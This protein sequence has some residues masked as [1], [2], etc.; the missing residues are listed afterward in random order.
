MPSSALCVGRKS[1]GV[2]ARVASVSG[3]RSTSIKNSYSVRPSVAR[4]RKSKTSEAANQT[5][6]TWRTGSMSASSVPVSTSV[7]TVTGSYS[8]R[9]P[10]AAGTAAYVPSA[11]SKS[12]NTWTQMTGS[13]AHPL[14]TVR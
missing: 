8:L 10:K 2:T 7:S 4:S 14:C 3:H 5:N 9:V 1:T 6:A 12:F 13:A 11:S